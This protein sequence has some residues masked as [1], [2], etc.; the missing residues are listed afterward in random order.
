MVE[1]LGT[2]APLLPKTHHRK[3]FHLELLKLILYL[4]QEISAKFI[5]CNVTY[6]W[7]YNS[8]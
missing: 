6:H 3:S 5:T 4:V 8:V 7:N 1:S 2:N